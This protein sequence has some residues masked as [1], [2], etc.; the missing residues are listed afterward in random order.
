MGRIRKNG[1]G[2]PTPGGAAPARG[3]RGLPRARAGF[4]PAA[5]RGAF[6]E[7]RGPGVRR[8]APGGPGSR[9][10]V[11]GKCRAWRRKRRAPRAPRGRRLAERTGP[12]EPGQG[13]GSPVT[14]HRARPINTTFLFQNWVIMRGRDCLTFHLH[15]ITLLILR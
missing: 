2:L 4:R 5:L 11:P 12:A 7:P 15:C 3:S 9:V 10:D 6:R 14:E 13:S 8:A 1:P